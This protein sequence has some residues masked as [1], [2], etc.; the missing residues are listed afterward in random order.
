MREKRYAARV[1]V[2]LEPDLLEKL[3][4]LSREKGIS[5]A[6]L[7]RMAVREWLKSMK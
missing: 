1:S 7:V 5:L 6:G 3:Q 2:A 4:D